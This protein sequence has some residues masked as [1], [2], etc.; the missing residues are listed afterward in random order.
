MIKLL[1][2]LYRYLKP[3]VSKQMTGLLSTLMYDEVP[4]NAYF[5]YEKDTNQMLYFIGREYGV[6]KIKHGDKVCVISNKYKS[7]QHLEQCYV[8]L[9]EQLSKSKTRLNHYPFFYKSMIYTTIA[10]NPEDKQFTPTAR[11]FSVIES[12]FIPKGKA[13]LFGEPEF[14]GVLSTHGSLDSVG[15]LVNPAHIQ[16]VDV[17]KAFKRK[18]ECGI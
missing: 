8:D 3:K 2:G 12:D 18:F 16:V 13:Y 10:V 1:D 6:E 5:V 15:I 14:I 7:V 4:T 9:L 17:E 11:G